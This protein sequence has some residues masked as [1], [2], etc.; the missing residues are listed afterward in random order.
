MKARGKVGR[1]NRIEGLQFELLLE[2]EARRQSVLTIKM[3][4]GCRR[5]GPHK[6]IQ[7][8][9]PFDYILIHDGVSSYV[10]AKSFNTDSVSFSQLTDHQIVTLK[11]IQESGAKAGYLVFHRPSNIIAFYKASLLCKL[12]SGM[13]C[14]YSEAEYLGKFEDFCLGNLFYD[15]PH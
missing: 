10:D 1:F 5:V 4:L 11:R 15:R 12:Q 6:L 3:P 9:T 8:K 2:R 13:S 14:H 7:I